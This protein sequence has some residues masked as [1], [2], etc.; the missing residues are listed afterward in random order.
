VLT[1][2]AQLRGRPM[3]RIAVPLRRMGATVLGREGGRLPPLA[4]RGGGLRGIEYAPPVASAQVKSAVLLAGL[5]ADGPT[6]VR[7]R[8]LTRDHTERMLTAM[9]ASLRIGKKATTLTPPS[10]LL[11]PLAMAIPGDFSSAA[12][13]LVAGL[14]V[15]GSE[16]VVHDVG[17]NPTRTGLLDV[18]QAM[19]AGI[20]VEP[21]DASAPEPLADLVAR[22][23][24]LHGTRI[25]GDLV[26]RMIDEFPILAVAATQAVGETV[27]TDA[28]ELRVKESNRLTAIV[29][30]LRRM[31]ARIE[32]REDGFVVEG[33]SRL[34]GAVVSSHDD[35][36]LAMALAV[37]GMV[38]EGE[39]HIE[40]F[41]CVSKSFPDFARRFAELGV[42]WR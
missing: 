20:E 6:T 26:P 12:F 1:G 33:P 19:G 21:K 41:G 34:H 17:V 3:D 29:T 27:V 39:T 25:G 18:L 14:L 28:H 2:N 7:E 42:S 11:E 5:L 9:G 37:A 10:H 4:I 36:R 24:E 32:E 23:V 13:F 38:A 15:P 40:G 16:L 8:W 30:E 35:H 22:P 31:G